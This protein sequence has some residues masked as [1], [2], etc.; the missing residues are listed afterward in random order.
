[1]YVFQKISLG[2]ILSVIGLVICEDEPE[3]KDPWD[4]STDKYRH[5]TGNS[6]SPDEPVKIDVT[7]VS[8]SEVHSSKS[9]VCR[10]CNSNI[11]VQETPHTAN[12]TK[13]ER[14]SNIGTIKKEIDEETKEQIKD[15]TDEKVP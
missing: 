4:K 1:M 12:S 5:N 15:A 13:S 3:E 6:D 9:N 11:V 7:E 2:I 8:E 14:S 10:D